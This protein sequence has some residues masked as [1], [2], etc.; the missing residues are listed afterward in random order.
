MIIECAN[1][2]PWDFD[3]VPTRADISM[4]HSL[5]I[6]LENSGCHRDVERLLPGFLSQID[7]N[8]NE[9]IELSLM[10]GAGAYL[11]R[12]AEASG[13]VA[14]RLASQ[15]PVYVTAR[16]D[17]QSYVVAVLNA[18]P[19]TVTKAQS[20]AEF[21]FHENTP[22]SLFKQMS[23]D[24]RLISYF[25]AAAGGA[26]FVPTPD[27]V[28]NNWATA[29]I[30]ATP[31]TLAKVQAALDWTGAPVLNAP[32]QVLQTTRQ[33]NAEV[34]QGTDGVVV[35]KILRFQNHHGE[36][37]AVALLL[38]REI[39]FPL[40]I[41]DPFQQMGRGVFKIDTVDDLLA[42]LPSLGNSEFYAIAF[43]D[44]PLKPGLYRKYRAAV[45]GSQI[46]ISHV[47]FNNSWSVHRIRDEAQQGQIDTAVSNMAQAESLM[48]HLETPEN[49]RVWQRLQNLCRKIPLDFFGVDFDVMPDGRLLFFEA[50]AAMNLSFSV[51]D[52]S[53]A[54]MRGGM[55]AAMLDLIKRK[56][57]T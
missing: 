9:D 27:I 34:L 25:P 46:F 4:T 44:N 52:K 30:L 38:E 32:F 41:R 50:N 10:R 37:I 56:I 29:E 2:V 12:D 33:R 7:V 11:K 8:E 43:I 6:A 39:G 17:S 14:E 49:K 18:P 28:I 51:N 42:L 55:Q 22:A 5:M 36:R 3:T 40:I 26:S 31:G 54:V 35:P 48:H 24:L 47:R 20:L 23:G 13:R 53:K 57:G 21:H 45:I 16:G 1:I 19:S 15:A